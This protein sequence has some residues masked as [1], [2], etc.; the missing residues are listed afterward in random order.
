MDAARFSGN[1]RRRRDRKTGDR[2]LKRS[3]VDKNEQAVSRWREAVAW[4]AGL[5]RVVPFRFFAR[6]RLFNAS[7]RRGYGPVT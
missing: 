7:V 3:A 4:R 1:V 6:S 2:F 5:V